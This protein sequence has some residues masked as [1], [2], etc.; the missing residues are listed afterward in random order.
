MGSS[1]RHFCCF[2]GPRKTISFIK[3]IFLLLSVVEWVVLNE[4]R[5]CISASLIKATNLCRWQNVRSLKIQLQIKSPII[6]FK[7]VFFFHST[8]WLIADRSCSRWVER[9]EAPRNA[10]LAC[11]PHAYCPIAS[12]LLP[13]KIVI[14]LEIFPSNGKKM[15]AWKTQTKIYYFD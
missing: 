5:L 12:C 4:C 3:C 14:I 1:P 8:N 13:T 2:L 15:W 7:I 6:F 10:R 9:R 11:F